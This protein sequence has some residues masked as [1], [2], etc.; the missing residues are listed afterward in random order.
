MPKF[1]SEPEIGEFRERLCEAAA[2]IFRSAGPERLQHA[3]TGGGHRRQRDDLPYRYFRDKDE[4]LAAVRARA[5]DRFASTL[6]EA[7]MVPGGTMVKSRAVGRAY[8]EFAFSQ[9]GSYRLMFDVWQPDENIYPDLD[10]F[11]HDEARA[12]MTRHVERL[13]ADDVLK[14]D[15]TLISHIFWATLTMARSCL[16]LPANETGMQLRYDR[17]DGLAESAPVQKLFRQAETVKLPVRLMHRYAARRPGG[18]R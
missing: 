12:M 16:N 13:V 7:F 14:S 15:P 2:C 8:T 1:L 3:R 18:R 6:E 10:T 9:P 5:Y 17:A 11:R 4:I